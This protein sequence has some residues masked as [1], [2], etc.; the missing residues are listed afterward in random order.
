MNYEDLTKD[1]RSLL[2]YL[3][4]CLV[5]HRGF[6]DMQRMNAEDTEIAKGWH[7]SGFIEFRRV[8]MKN[9][10][11]SHCTHF[12]RFTDDAWKLAHQE[13]KARSKRILS[14]IILES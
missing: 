1:E 5:D 7:E 10:T 3:E 14:T 8:K 4:W 12:V 9:I 11:D 13:R 6:V 2:L